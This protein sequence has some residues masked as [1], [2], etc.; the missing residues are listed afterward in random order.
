[1]KD[2]N[3][4]PPLG[5]LD[6]K[7]SAAKKQRQN[8]ASHSGKAAGVSHGMKAGL[9]LVSGVAV[10]TGIGY[11]LDQWFGTLPLFMLICM[12]VGTAAGIKLMVETSNRAVA[13]LE[14]EEKE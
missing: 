3:T 12:S 2:Q 14:E 4:P 13:A 5:D 8:N 1:M 10:G 9:D 11:G 7:I 6:N